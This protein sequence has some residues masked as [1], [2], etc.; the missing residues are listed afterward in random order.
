MKNGSVLIKDKKID[1]ILA[2]SE[3]EQRKGLMFVEPPVPNMA[4]VFKRAGIHKF[5]MNKT[6]AP[7]DIIFCSNNRIVDI[8]YGEPM[9]TR[10]VGPNIPVDLVIEVPFGKAK[11][12]NINIGDFVRSNF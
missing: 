12:Y 11:E 9:S 3:E 1:V 8:C 10:Q 2:L 5:W 6:P 4:F 7:L